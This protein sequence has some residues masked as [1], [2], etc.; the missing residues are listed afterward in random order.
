MPLLIL[1]L[2]LFGI[3][4]LAWVAAA[5]LLVGTTL[6]RTPNLLDKVLNYKGKHCA[7]HF[8]ERHGL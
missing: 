5:G 3:L 7:C 1:F 6:S 2:I 4:A 8:P